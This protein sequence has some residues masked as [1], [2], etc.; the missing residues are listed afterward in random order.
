MH[1]KVLVCEVL[2]REIFHCAAR[3]PNT[4]DIELFTQGLHDNS[5]VCRETLQPRIDSADAE[6]YDAVLLAYGLCNNAVVGLRA[7]PVPLVIPRAHD[8]ITLFLG[9]RKRY[10]EVFSQRP[11]T[12]YYTSG[13]LE[14]AS[15]GG[16][17]VEPDAKSGLGPQRNLQYDKLVE[18]YGEDNAKY[19][20]EAMSGWQ[21]NYTHGIYIAF[22]WLAHLDLEKRVRRVCTDNEWEFVAIDGDLGLLEQMLSGEWSEEDFLRVEPG[23]RIAAVHDGS[24][25]AAR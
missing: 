4:V 5:D 19:L 9:S 25:V 14:Y 8:C 10:D 16:D 24:I 7:G 18:Q 15:R 17:R 20:M 2:A 1:L 3:T 6:T 22:P 11:G 21:R 12:Y 23:Q 13:W